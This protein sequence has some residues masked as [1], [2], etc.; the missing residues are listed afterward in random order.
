MRL[1]L[2]TA[3]VL[4]LPLRLCSRLLLLAWRPGSKV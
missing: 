2:P 3:A 4:L 1:I